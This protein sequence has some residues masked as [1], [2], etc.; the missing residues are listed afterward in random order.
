MSSNNSIKNLNIPNNCVAI[1]PEAYCVVAEQPNQVV[2]KYRLSQMAYDLWEKDP[3]PITKNDN[4]L[5]TNKTCVLTN[6][7]SNTTLKPGCVATCMIK[8]NNNA[9]PWSEQD[10][11]NYIGQTLVFDGANWTSNTLIPS[12]E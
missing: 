9:G 10:N 3:N 1:G 11:S 8:V 4:S 7:C 5:V 12:H 6:G 2:S